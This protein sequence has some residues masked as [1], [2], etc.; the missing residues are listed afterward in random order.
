MQR[1]TEEFRQRATKT[2]YLAVALAM[3]TA[4]QGVT[5]FF[6]L[7]ELLGGG[8]EGTVIPALGAL[9][10]G[11]A[12]W[13]AWHWLSG[14]GPLS[15][16]PVSRTMFIVIAGVLT[17]VSIGTSS[18][19]L[20]ANI[21][22]GAAIR[23]HMREYIGAATS[24]LADLSANA[25]A[26]HEL[27]AKIVRT[28]ASWRAM[29]DDEKRGKLGNPAGDGPRAATLRRAAED[30]QALNTTVNETFEKSKDSRDRARGILQELVVLA[31]G[32][33]GLGE[34]GQARFAELSARLHANF[35]ETNQITALPMIEKTGVIDVTNMGNLV[36]SKDEQFT[37]SLVESA[38]RLK[39][40]RR[41]LKTAIYEPTTRSQA[42]IDN[43]EVAIPGWIVAVAFDTL[44]LL[45]FLMMLVGY[46]KAHPGTLSFASPGQA[47]GAHLAGELLKAEAGVDMLHVPYTGIAPAMNDVVGGRVSLM[48]LGISAALPYIRTGALRPLGV[49][50][51]KRSPLLPDVP[52][53][54]EQGYPGFD[55]TSWYGVALRSGTPADIFDRLY[56]EIAEILK[57]DDIKER[58]ASMG[59]EPGGLTPQAF[60]E[61]VRSESIKWRDIIVRAN[62]RL[63]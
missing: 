34:E 56:R 15:H 23:G 19:F 27:G 7:R 3:V 16:N 35:A 41:P 63:E 33:K 5:I 22:G 18:W 17:M 39:E 11:I 47:T 61:L 38:R 42:V 60:A 48:F 12:F 28:A 10:I 50:A 4:L 31:N 37:K 29:A 1:Y 40:E 59:V 32:K 57:L 13:I 46:A 30:M 44:P 8:A 26:E 20:S 6:S 21:S 43:F 51:L 53:V 45:M 49:A 52:L 55:V 14:V 9:V 54:A 36:S 62:I 25:E 2:G 58:F 24:Q